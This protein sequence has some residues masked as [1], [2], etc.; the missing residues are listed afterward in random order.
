MKKR[1]LEDNKKGDIVKQILE[2]RR[3]KDNQQ[4]KR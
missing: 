2:D 4:N 1:K 3:S